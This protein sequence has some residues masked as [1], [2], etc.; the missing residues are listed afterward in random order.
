MG[1]SGRRGRW[2]GRAGFLV[3]T[4]VASACATTRGRDYGEVTVRE[5]AAHPRGGAQA[6][7]DR[8]R[9][10]IAVVETDVGRGMG[11]VIDPSGYL[12]T[13]RHVIEDADHIVSVQFPELSPPRTYESIQVVYTDPEH[14][15]A[16]LKINAEEPLPF[17][18]LATRKVLPISRYLAVADP[19]TTFRRSD[20][21]GIVEL[22]SFDHG[23]V[24][25]LAVY[26]ASAGPGAFLGVSAPIRR[27]QS[28][29]PVLDDAGR[30]VGVVT[31]TWRE[32]KGGFAIPIAEATRMLQQ[33][34]ELDG[35]P[36]RLERATSR[37][38]KFLTALGRGDVE[39]A[40]RI[41]SP[42]FA[43]K[44]RGEAVAAILG[45]ADDDRAMPVMQGFVAAVESLVKKP[46][47]GT[48]LAYDRLREMV[49]RT[50]TDA[51]REELGLAETMETSQV[52]S[53]FFEFG[54]AYYAARSFGNEE[55]QAAVAA[56][57]RRLQTIDAARTFALATTLDTLAG[58]AVE[59][60]TV[61]L[62]PGAYA[63]KALVTLTRDKLGTATEDGDISLHL[64]LEW[65]DWYIAAVGRSALS[66]AG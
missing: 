28:G 12:I 3:L 23:K 42:S 13:N 31:W 1:T 63:P 66:D 18:P 59:I 65:G 57:M 48:E 37:S 29:G 7:V 26:N 47:E 55:P 22:L 43:R 27:G 2:L 36:A 54:Q 15:L 51:F 11:F 52:V 64:R 49:A 30:A 45:A 20:G 44:V 50:G 32:S 46:G 16:L 5:G 21:E 40:R 10:G 19:I 61:E 25:D 41:T 39:G 62:V 56:A 17:V 58:N 60:D 24:A 35:E 14:D 9:K 34:P 33:R 38:R 53:F 4:L 8:S 6:Q